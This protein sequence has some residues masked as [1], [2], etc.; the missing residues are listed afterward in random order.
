MLTR[1]IYIKGFNVYSGSEVQAPH[2]LVVVLS[3]TL[4]HEDCI[5]S[6]QDGKIAEYTVSHG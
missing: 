4:G 1:Y 5:L 3:T 2:L 6:C